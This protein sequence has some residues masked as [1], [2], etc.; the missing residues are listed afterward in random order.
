MAKAALLAVVVAVL[1]ACR[2]RP[3]MDGT[4]LPVSIG[5][6][7][8]PPLGSGG[9]AEKKAVDRFCAVSRI[10][11][12]SLAGVESVN[13]RLDQYVALLGG[14]AGFP[15]VYLI[16]VTWPGILAEHLLDLGPALGPESRRHLPAVIKNN[17]VDGRLLAMPAW[18]DG[19]LLYYRTDL[20]EKYGFR[21]PPRTWD[22]LE[23]M[24]AVIQAGE[25]SRGHQG[26]WGF[27]WQGGPAE[28]LT[29]NALEWQASHGGGRII[30]K[31]GRISIN[32]PRVIQA[33]ERARR[34]VGTISPPGVVTYREEDGRNLWQAGQV[35]FMR[36][37]PYCYLPG[38][39]EGSPIRGRFAVAALPSG[40]AGPVHTLGGWQLAVS[41]YSAH[42]KE[43]VAFVR[44]MAGREVQVSRALEASHVPT[45]L[46]LYD[47]PEVLGA[48]PYYA[49]LQD[50]FTEGMVLRP[51][52][53]AGARYPQ[54]S[55]AYFTTVHSVLTG[56]V[57]AARAV[58]DLET[59]LATLTGLRPGPPDPV[60]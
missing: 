11:V 43:A 37:W 54:V 38:D 2:D 53:I 29:C 30:E 39:A 4:E 15:D 31:D 27:V 24:A 16:D 32:N 48:N 3:R 5:Y 56:R 10:R 22:Q 33:F 50:V 21:A 40:G 52:G 44:F 23:H 59:R 17:T 7:T 12:T 58:A 35:A 18:I 60:P 9:T 41:K 49:R 55:E 51:S 25:R 47:D 20:L 13:A 8:L 28:G 45:L 19:G 46:E 36:N 14:R 6:H 1:G 34:W 57:P 42:P 26:F